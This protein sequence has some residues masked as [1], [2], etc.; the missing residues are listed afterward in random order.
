MMQSPS[1]SPPKSP[2]LHAILASNVATP[3]PHEGTQLAEAAPQLDLPQRIDA[4]ETIKTPPRVPAMARDDRVRKALFSPHA[5]ALRRLRHQIQRSYPNGDELVAR[6]ACCSV[7]KLKTTDNAVSAKLI[8]EYSMLAE[9]S[10]RAGR[11]DAECTAHLW[12]VASC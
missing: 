10:K 11:H 7:Q 5:V 12:W 9:S 1:K 8:K 6:L 4:P 3:N 2:S